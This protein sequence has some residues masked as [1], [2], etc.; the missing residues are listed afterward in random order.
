VYLTTLAL[1]AAASSSSAV[2]ELPKRIIKNNN[3]IG[4]YNR[5][6]RDE[7]GGEGKKRLSSTE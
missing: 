4:G 1:A 7:D 5:G 6:L 3:P 2:S